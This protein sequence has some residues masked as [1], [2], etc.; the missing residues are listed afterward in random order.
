[1]CN[2]GRNPL[3]EIVPQ[4][5]GTFKCSYFSAAEYCFVVSFLSL[6]QFLAGADTIAIS[7]HL[8]VG[9]TQ[10]TSPLALI[11]HLIQYSSRYLAAAVMYTCTL[12]SHF[13]L[14]SR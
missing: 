4:S 3:F 10:I 2:G 14:D 12:R 9:C 1:M 6:L 7:L 5:D 8:E 11:M 13:T